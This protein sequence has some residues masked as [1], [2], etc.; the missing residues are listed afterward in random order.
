MGAGVVGMMS[1]ADITENLNAMERAQ[2]RIVLYDL[3]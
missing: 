3:S 1:G 2:K